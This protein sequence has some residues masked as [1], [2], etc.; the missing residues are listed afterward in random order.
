MNKL[1][2]MNNQENNSKTSSIKNWWAARTVAQKILLI[3][4]GGGLLFVLSK[5][6]DMGP[7]ACDCANLYE[8]SPWK[9][10]YTAQELNDG[11][12]LRKDANDYVE[13]GKRCA[14]KYG[15]LS[16]IEAELA[17]STLE[18]NM[19]PNLDKAIENARKE[20]GTK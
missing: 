18:M 3:F 1:E 8:N 2:F 6:A 16:D 20:C 7:T 13:K 17:K 4:L 10:N 19:I 15:N 5:G 11:T 9:K 12:T 14:I